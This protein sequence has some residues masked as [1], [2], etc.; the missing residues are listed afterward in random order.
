MPLP[1]E[2]YDL[3]VVSDLHLSEG[4]SSLTKKFSPNED[5]FFDEEFGR[6]LHYYM[7]RMPERGAGRRWHL[8]INGDFLDFLQVTCS[9]MSAEFLEYLGV[10]TPAEA[11]A[12]LSYD[13]RHLDYGLGCGLKETVYKLWKIMDGHWQF[14]R[15]LAEFIAEGNV[16][17]IGRGN[18][19]VEFCYPEVQ[20]AFAPKLRKIYAE[21]L[22]REHNPDAAD[23]LGRLDNACRDGAIRFLDWFYYERGKLW[24]EHGN[25]Y[26]NLNCFKCWL[27]PLLPEIPNW[28]PKRRDEIDL[29]WG[30]L[31]VRYLFN[32][33]E[34]DEPFAD[35]IKPQSKFISWFL[36][37][38]PALALRFLFG[39]GRYMLAKM[40]RSWRRLP[41]NAYA[42]RE[43]VQKATLNGL[44]AKWNIPPGRLRQI[45]AIRAA[46]VLKEDPPD[47]WWR[48]IRFLVRHRL[49]LPG[50]VVLLIVGLV[51]AVFVACS[52]LGP[53]FPSVVRH[54]FGSLSSWVV[55]HRAVAAILWASQWLLFVAASLGTY[56]FV[57]L[58]F[59]NK[60]PA[61]NDLFE[62][63][64]QISALLD[65]RYVSMGHTHDTDL[66]S[67]AP[68]AR[69]YFNTGTWTKVF[70]EEERLIQEES[71]LVFLCGM[72]LDGD[73]TMKLLKWNDAV[74]EPRL[75]KLFDAAEVEDRSFPEQPK[76]SRGGAR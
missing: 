36:G 24:I 73:L 53:H 3:L 12:Q 50:V 21:K 57:R 9:E 20:A 37:H 64:K 54:W 39:D 44:A 74:G 27:A 55:G 68:D 7:D 11:F 31:F 75:V 72:R 60:P 45:D 43:E 59:A 51:L 22:H 19:D 35:N 56:L 33:V 13:R 14:F 67:L 2:A 30:S 1:D 63:A 15:A 32:Q 6:F 76:R 5:F 49:L 46:N 42:G 47:A 8:V 16:V 71:E 66:Q 52:V 29:P 70:S 38:H 26:D 10:K 62:R 28:D 40:R 41:P 17:S 48:L 4:R 34:T 69:E 25:Q 18:H 65:V 61:P 23:E 58:F